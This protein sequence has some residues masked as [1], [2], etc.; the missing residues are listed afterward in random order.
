MNID[1]FCLQPI[2]LSKEIFINIHQKK[3]IPNSNT[4]IETTNE[5]SVDRLKNSNIPEKWFSEIKSI[6]RQRIYINNSS[7]V[8]FNSDIRPINDLKIFSKSLSVNSDKSGFF[9]GYDY[10]YKV[11]F[12]SILSISRCQF[13][14]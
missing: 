12:F 1:F 2:K 11:F 3:Y 13:I 7:Y 5:K 9:L 6:K 8:K 14:N 10:D 4:W